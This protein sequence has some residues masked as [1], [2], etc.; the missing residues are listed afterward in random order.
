MPGRGTTRSGKTYQMSDGSDGGNAAPL[1]PAAHGGPQ[2]GTPP[3]APQTTATGGSQSVTQPSIDP[4]FLATLV[5]TTVSETLS[6]LSTH[7]ISL[8]PTG[9]TPVPSTSS[10]GKSI[11]T[12]DLPTFTGKSVDGYEAQVFLDNLETLYDISRTPE[13]D[14]VKYASLGFPPLSPATF[15]FTNSKN[16][17]IFRTQ[18]DPVDTLRYDLFR[19]AFLSRY[20][21]PT[22]RRYALE[23]LW[24]KFV[25]KGTV[26]EHQARFNRLLFQLQQ[27][28]INYQSDVI[29]S[30]YLRSLKPDLFSL[31]C[32]KNK[33]LPDFEVIHTQ[34]VEAEYQQKTA[35]ATPS[36]K[37]LFPGSTS[38]PKKTFWCELHKENNTHDTK[39]CFRIQSLKRQGK[40]NNNKDKHNQKENQK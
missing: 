38:T 16:E 13:E 37:G 18:T 19:T 34:A 14:K 26:A 32:N 9:S 11:R 33:S 10:G 23:D 5:S 17:G 20:T 1:Q 21:T 24:D 15:W 36:L 8:G 30:K 28:G 6:A 39:D 27:L 4:Q 22:S 25:Q 3:V 7:N 12:S 35:R 31:V 40:W 29:A 2:S